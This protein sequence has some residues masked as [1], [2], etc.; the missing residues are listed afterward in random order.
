MFQNIL[1]DT[2]NKTDRLKTG[3]SLLKYFQKYFDPL[4]LSY[5]VQ[6]VHVCKTLN[7][8]VIVYIVYKCLIVSVQKCPNTLDFNVSFVR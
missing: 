7:I 5:I 8:F 3:A 6:T 4:F 2:N 1:N